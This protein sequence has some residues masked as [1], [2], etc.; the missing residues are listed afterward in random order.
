MKNFFVAAMIAVSLFISQNA[1]AACEFSSCAGSVPADSG[2]TAKRCYNHNGI[3][4][5]N[6]EG[7][8][9][10]AYCQSGW[11]YFNSAC[12]INWSV[13]TQNMDGRKLCVSYQGCSLAPKVSEETVSTSGTES[14][15]DKAFAPNNPNIG[16]EYFGWVTV[17]S[18]AT[19]RTGN[20]GRTTSIKARLD[21]CM[22]GNDT[23]GAIA[24]NNA[25]T[26]YQQYCGTS[27]N[28]Y[29]NA[30]G[31][32]GGTTETAAVC[33]DRCECAINGTTHSTCQ[34]L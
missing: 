22:G 27:Y 23:D 4:C 31:N 25:S 32:N 30:S 12:P 17:N 7:L 19:N 9:S 34:N 20:T 6:L 1:N 2:V 11:Y 16:D 14:G 5:T 33:H 15:L 24:T 18:V 3:I 26:C 21:I 28:E 29:C 13:Y 10:G 8:N